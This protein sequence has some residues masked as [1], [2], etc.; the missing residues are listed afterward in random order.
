MASASNPCLQPPTNNMRQNA[1]VEMCAQRLNLSLHTS[2]ITVLAWQL[3]INEGK[4]L[5]AV[6]KFTTKYGMLKAAA[7]WEVSNHIKASIW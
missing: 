1:L 2:T 7:I 3:H 5:R 4:N 6:A